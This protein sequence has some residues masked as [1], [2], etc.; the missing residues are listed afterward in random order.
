MQIENH[1]EE[2]P[3]AHYEEAFRKADP[4]EIAGRLSYVRWDGAEFFLTLLGREY[5][6]SHP[7]CEIRP[8]DGGKLPPLPTQTVLLRVLLE[9]REIPWKGD[10]LCNPVFLGVPGGSDS[11]EFNAMRKTW[12]QSLGSEDPLE[13]GMATHSSI[14]A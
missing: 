9:S 6:V 12:V 1:K 8:T 11:Q 2:V 13:E 14:L 3:F 7:G 10:K 5:A 4:A